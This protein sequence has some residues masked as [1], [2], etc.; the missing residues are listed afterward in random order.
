MSGYGQNKIVL[1]ILNFYREKLN[2]KI[3]KLI[4]KKGTMCVD[5]S[6]KWGKSR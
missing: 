3:L 6:L 4:R 1:S 5:I 2:F